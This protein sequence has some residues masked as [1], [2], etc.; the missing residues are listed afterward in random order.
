MNPKAFLP[1]LFCAAL[2]LFPQAGMAQDDSTGPATAAEREALYTE[3]LERRVDDILK[4]LNLTDAAK[5]DRVKTTLT[6][7]YRTLRARDEVINAKLK[8]DGKAPDDYAARAEWR[9]KLSQPLHDWFLSILAL[10]L[11]P[12]QIETIKDAMTYNKVKVTYE[13]YCQ[14]IPGLKEA[15]KARILEMLKTA[16]EEAMDGGSAPEKS[17][18]FQLHKETINAYLNTSGYDVAKAYKEW[19]AKNPPTTPGS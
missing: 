11:T 2:A 6:L 18:I 12:E 16:R 3:S 14:I 17:E 1:I 4:R 8:A 5:A 7:Q 19:E 9:R 13:A 15:D 10:D